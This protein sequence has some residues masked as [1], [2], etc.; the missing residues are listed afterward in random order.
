MF[1]IFQNIKKERD[2]TASTGLTKATF[3]ALWV[4]FKPHY[5]P[6]PFHLIANLPAVLTDPEEALFFILYQL[7]TYTN[8]SCVVF[9]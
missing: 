2:Y 1:S 7:K 8:L 5:Q 4:I 9:Y 3:E 6:K